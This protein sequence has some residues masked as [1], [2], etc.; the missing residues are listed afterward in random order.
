MMNINNT[1]LDAKEKALN[2]VN[3]TSHCDNNEKNFI[4]LAS[5]NIVDSKYKAINQGLGLR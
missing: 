1:L 3:I 2:K 4:T 5:S